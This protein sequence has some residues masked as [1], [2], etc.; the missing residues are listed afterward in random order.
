MNF[1]DFADVLPPL[2]H[3]MDGGAA[4]ADWPP[5]SADEIDALAHHV[6]ALRGPR[7]IAWHSPRPFSAAALVRCAPDAPFGE[8]FVK[9]HDARVRDAASLHEEHRFLD[10]LRAAGREVPV[11]LPLAGPDGAPATA[12][13]LGG[14]TYE[15][16]ARAPGL[17]LYRDAHS[18]TPVR[19]VGHA[20]ALGRALA[21]MHCAAAGFA[22]RARAARPLL[23]SFDIV[24][25]QALPQAL[26]RFLA[27]RPA[28][29]RFVGGPEARERILAALEPWHRRLRPLLGR[30]EPLW[31]HNDWHASNAFWTG[32]GAQAQVCAAIDF[33]LCNLGCA[34]ADLAT[35]LERNTI[36]WLDRDPAQADGGGAIGVLPLALALL[37]GY[38]A[39]RP[40]D[41]AEREALPWILPLAHV[42]FA[43]SE[44]DYFA[45]IVGN[46]AHARLAYPQFLLGHVQWFGSPDGRE[47]LEGLRRF[48]DAPAPRAA[49]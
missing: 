38:F 30:L 2:V 12:L 33:G 13:T 21:Q 8:V 10:H 3:G 19:G 26:E 14:R 16:H 18:W 4:P 49:R 41:P 40:L 24:G 11:V 17:D 47:Y 35:A 45:G 42:E 23:A 34:A 22:A 36:A 48:L 9:R 6:P 25:A 43:L 1:T 5:L 20:R 37:E 27:L 46:P 31:V 15:V 7:R 39:E 32:D 29:G 44:V 28:A